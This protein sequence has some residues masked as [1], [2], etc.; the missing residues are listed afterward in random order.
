MRFNQDAVAT[1][2][3]SDNIWVKCPSCHCL[4]QVQSE[5]DKY[6]FPQSI[7]YH[8]KFTCTNC[9]LFKND[10]TEW[11]GSFRG[12]VYQPCHFCG[13]KVLFTTKPSK[14]KYK[15]E[16]VVCN[17]CQKKLDYKLTW[18]RYKDDKTIDP[19]F[20]LDLWMQVNIK[21]KTLWL[22]NLEHLHYLRDYIQA[23]LREDDNRH[24]YS[25]ITNLPQWVKSAKN[26][27]LIIKK[28]N[29]LENGIYKKIKST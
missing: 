27:E 5:S 10:N 16:S 9:N 20:G 22:Y 14:E 17:N 23:K 21:S 18:S 2:H 1:I 4:G 19:Y 8:A 12:S 25:M 3:F 15:T 28:L 13:T 6:I 7:N 11:F 26:K 24:K 29:Q